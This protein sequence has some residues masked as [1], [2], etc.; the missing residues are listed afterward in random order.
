MGRSRGGT[1]GAGD[2]EGREVIRGERIAVIADDLTGACDAGAQFAARG[3]STRVVFDVEGLEGARGADVVVLDTESRALSARAAARAVRRACRGL[4][5]AGIVRV[6]KKIDS[7]LR[8]QVAV[9]YEAMLAAWPEIGAIFV[10]P[11]FPAARRVTREGIVLV[12]GIPLHRT[13]A[14]RDPRSPVRES[15]LPAFLQRRTRRG[16]AHIG[17]REVRLGRDAIL[18]CA[19]AECSAGVQI[20]ACD[21]VTAADLRR[22]AQAIAAFSPLFVP[23]GSAGL[24]RELALLWGPRG[25]TRRV[26]AAGRPP[27][28]RRSLPILV[29]AGSPNPL[30]AAQAAHA[31]RAGGAVLIP[32]DGRAVAR[33]G[34]SGAGAAAIRRAAAAAL[35]AMGSGRDVVLRVGGPVP[36]GAAAAGRVAAGLGAVARWVLRRRRVPLI[37]VGGETAIAVCRALGVDGIEVE[38]E[39]LPGIPLA[40]LSGGLAPGVPIVTKAGGFGGP[41]ALIPLMRSLRASF[42]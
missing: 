13:A 3:L 40:W 41:D 27:G 4:R 39:V 16:V 22:L 42:P 34:G 17:L 28:A 14:A 26:R 2:R 7:T 5:A 21:A 8:G 29:V 23:S 11:A 32:L 15:H 35:A 12:G 20:F 10:A 37:L 36:R 33:H 9:E 1:Q 38:R 30:A 19:L 25:R 18:D 6:Y 24:A 31:R